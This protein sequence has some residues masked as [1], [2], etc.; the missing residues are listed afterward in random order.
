[1]RRLCARTQAP[2]R[3]GPAA[4]YVP[5]HR[6]RVLEAVDCTSSPRAT[7]RGCLGGA[8]GPP[9]HRSA[10]DC[11]RRVGAVLAAFAVFFFPTPAFAAFD[12]FFAERSRFALVEAGASVLVPCVASSRAALI[13]TACS[14]ILRR[15]AS[16]A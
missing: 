2:A 3:A 15:W 1:P 9:A 8:V 14:T 16:E 10:F 7:A 6:G 4:R 12:V 13:A 11:R 5:A